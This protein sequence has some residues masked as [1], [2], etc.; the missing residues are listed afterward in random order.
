MFA[1]T[2]PPVLA[3]FDPDLPAV[4]QMY[5]SCLN[6]IGYDLLQDQGNGYL[7]LVQC[8]S[9]FLADAETRYATIELEILAVVWLM[10]NCR[11]YLAGL[12][13]FT[14]MTDHWPLIPILNSYTLNVI[15]TH[16]SRTSRRSH[17]TSLQLCGVLELLDIRDA[18]RADPA[19]TRQLDC[20]ITGFPRNRYNLH[21]SVLPYWK[22]RADLYANSD[23]VLY[24]ARVVVPAA[25]RHHFL[26]HLHDSHRGVKAT[27]CR[28]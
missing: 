19:Y 5:V 10:S 22:L 4:L 26:S 1:L 7:R 12:Q 24:R 3:L 18:T 16:V 2:Y 9:R 28:A 27:K 14:L 20:V 25:L 11:L 6:G 17:L 15:E 23:L 13:P 21:N 8:G